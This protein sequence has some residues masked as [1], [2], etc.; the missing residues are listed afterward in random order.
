MFFGRKLDIQQITEQLRSPANRSAPEILTVVGP[1]GCGKSSLVRAGV[2]PRLGANG[3]AAVGADRS[4]NLIRWAA[5]PRAGRDGPQAP[6]RCGCAALLKTCAA[7]HQGRRE[8]TAARADIDSRCKLL[9]VIDQFEE[10]LTQTER[11]LTVP[12]FVEALARAV[13]GPIQVLA[14]LR[15]EFLDMC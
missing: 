15:P 1:S 3:I 14:T 5:P 2:L 13:G 12:S 9:I 6:P 11:R 4:G 8:R 7:T 10:L